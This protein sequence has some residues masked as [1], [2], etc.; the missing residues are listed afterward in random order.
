[1]WCDSS[2]SPVIWMRNRMCYPSRQTFSY[3]LMWEL[4]VPPRRNSHQRPHPISPHW[5][6]P[7]K[8]RDMLVAHLLGVKEVEERDSADRWSTDLTVSATEP[9]LITPVSCSRGL[10]TRPLKA[11]NL[12]AYSILGATSTFPEVLSCM[13]FGLWFP[14]SI[15]PHLSE[16]H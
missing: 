5:L 3:F 1:M 4:I 12:S 14:F 8:G 15:W 9:Q 16:S 2:L 10:F 6:F 7:S 11:T 13:G